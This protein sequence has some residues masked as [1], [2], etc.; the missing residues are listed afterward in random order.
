MSY[1]TQDAQDAIEALNN[2]WSSGLGFNDSYTTIVDAMTGLV[3]SA[4]YDPTIKLVFASQ[5]V[6]TNAL[7][8]EPAQDGSIATYVQ[9]LTMFAPNFIKQFTNSDYTNPGGPR[10]YMLTALKQAILGGFWATDPDP[11]GLATWVGLIDPA[12]QAIAHTIGYDPEITVRGAAL[13]LLKSVNWPVSWAQAL[14][15]G[16][17]AL[18]DA[19]ASS[20][21][22]ATDRAS[23]SALSKDVR[24]RALTAANA[25]QSHN[26]KT[27]YAA[28]GTP[29]NITIDAPGKPWYKNGA[30]LSAG[31]LGLLGGIGIAVHRAKNK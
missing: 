28:D 23:L 22:S 3:Q 21:W 24:A 5:G 18:D 30:V 1:T 4:A 11:T 25:A 7:T 2:F 19:I 10:Y 13:D 6:F 26:F 20:S 8:S 15:G 27:I 9:Q 12:G 31:A 16:L 14:L 17:G 29:E